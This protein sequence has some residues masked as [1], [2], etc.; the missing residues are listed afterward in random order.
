MSNQNNSNKKSVQAKKAQLISI[1]VSVIAIVIVGLAF[2]YKDVILKQ[3]SIA[4][5]AKTEAKV[6]QNEK[7]DLLIPVKDVSETATFYKV[8]VENTD[9]EVFAIKA[10]DGSI[11]TAFNTCQ[12]CYDS[13]RGYYK[14][15]GDALVCQN[16]G[17]QFSANDVEVTRGGCNPVPITEEYKQVDSDNIIIPAEFLKE[18]AVIFEDWKSN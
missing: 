2:A 3:G 14:Q 13:G 1:I 10:S 7:G 12:V 5:D 6:V 17:N 8:N 9:I 18:V 16:C 4:S 11:R 15:N